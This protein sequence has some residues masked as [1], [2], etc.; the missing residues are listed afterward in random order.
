MDHANSQ[1]LGSRYAAIY[2]VLIVGHGNQGFGGQPRLPY[3]PTMRPSNT[4]QQSSG[5]QP[6]V[7]C[8]SSAGMQT[9]LHH[10][11][12]IL[13]INFPCLL[14][15]KETSTFCNKLLKGFHV[16]G[17]NQVGW[18]YNTAS[19]GPTMGVPIGMPRPATASGALPQLTS[20]PGQLHL[21]QLIRPATATGG[22]PQS[23][24][25]PGQPSV[26][27]P[28]NFSGAL[29]QPVGSRS[30]YVAMPAL[31][32][33]PAGQG[34]TQQLRPGY[35]QLASMSMAPVPARPRPSVN[36]DSQNPL[37]PQQGRAP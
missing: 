22:L 4:L 32:P 7:R 1:V 8:I 23:T 18:R 26:Q 33:P 6:L 28:N 35:S 17:A 36:Q 12:Y 21:Q 3:L 31:L 13:E 10:K 15:S 25:A 34:A 24:I 5:L 29:Q 11:L 37:S 2:F 14:K 19:R 9:N 16:Q 27:R 30:Q 20:P